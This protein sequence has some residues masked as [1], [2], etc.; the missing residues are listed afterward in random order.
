MAVLPNVLPAQQKTRLYIKIIASDTR[1]ITPA[2]VCI[3]N[4]SNL[5]VHLPPDGAVAGEAT[6]PDIFF[7]GINFSNNKN[8]VGPVRKMSGKGAVNG[9][10]TYVYGNAPTLPYWKEPVMYQVS[11]NFT[12]DLEPGTWRIS[13]EHG[14]EYVPVNSELTVKARPKEQTKTFVLK[15]WINLPKL[16]WYSGDVHAHHPLNRQSFREYVLQLAKAEDVHLLNILQMGDRSHIYFQ[17]EGFGDKFHIIHG[18][19]SIVSGQEEPRSNYGHIIGL[20]TEA[21][22]RDTAAY[23]HYDIVFNRIHHK[24]QSLAGY[25][26][27]AY[28]GEGVKEGLAIY[29][30]TG[31]IDFLELLQNTQLNTSDYYDYLNLGFRLTAAAGSDFPWGSTIGD[32]RTYVYTGNSFSAAKWFEGMK[33]G[34]TFVS[35][36]PAL[37]L[38]AAGN[39]PGAEANKHQGDQVTITVKALSNSNIGVIEKVQ[40]LNNDGLLTEALNTKHLNSVS[41]TI[42]H[43][44]LKSQWVTAAVYC[45][46]GALAHTSPVY[47]TVDGKSWYDSAKGPAIIQKLLV[48]LNNAKKTEN[49]KQPIDSGMIERIE[50]AELYYKRLMQ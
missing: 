44:L 30:P 39:L 46:N 48:I 19:T 27:F 21:L 31:A 20:N 2:M 25:A 15:R 22:A 28:G 14:N 24:Q 11:G 17:P 1:N 37:F 23:N 16:G 33:R 13:I 42:N 6:Y 40:L 45:S 41:L 5:K 34:N 47:F 3:T 12:I 7:G 49:S 43:Q 18:N 50:N 26:H 10:R 8:W 29:A 9:Q 36:G 32:G 4:K 38:K 35:N